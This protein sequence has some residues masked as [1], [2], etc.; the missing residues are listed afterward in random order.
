MR[1]GLAAGGTEAERSYM[2]RGGSRRRPPSTSVLEGRPHQAQKLCW[3]GVLLRMPELA[4]AGRAGRQGPTGRGWHDRLARSRVHVFGTEPCA[5]G[6]A[7]R[8][9]GMVRT[10]SR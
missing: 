5:G 7:C 3:H 6:A 8:R 4:E 9:S 10:E 2:P 1:R